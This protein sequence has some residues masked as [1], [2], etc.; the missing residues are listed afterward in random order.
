MNTRKDATLNKYKQYK[1]KLTSILRQ[2]EK[3]YF[4]R[5][6][7]EAKDNIAKTWSILN[8]MTRKNNGNSVV[9]KIVT[10]NTMISDPAVIAGKFNEFFLLMSVLIWLKKFQLARNHLLTS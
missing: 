1:N 7:L 4:S 3:D 2:A 10:G 5:K 8:R 6:I 9:N